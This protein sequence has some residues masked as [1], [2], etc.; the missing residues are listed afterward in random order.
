MTNIIFITSRL[1]ENHGGLTSSLLNKARILYNEKN[2]NSII[3]TFH[4]VTNFND[5]TSS[6]LERYKLEGKAEIYNI[7]EYFREKNLTFEHNKYNIDTSIYTSIKINDNKY[8][9]Y[10]YGLKRLEIFYSKNKIKEVK[11]FNKNNIC[12]SKDVIDIDGYLYWQSYYLNNHLSR[13]VFFRKDKTPFLTREFDAVNK[14]DK[15]ISLVL[16]EDKPIRF[17]SFNEFKE[18]FINYYIKAPI[19]YL[20]GEA[21][22]LDSVILNIKNDYA[23]KIFMTHS[24]HIRPDTDIIRAG[25]RKVLENLNEINALVLLTEK[26]KEDINKRFGHRDNYYVIPHSIAIPEVNQEKVDNK[27]VIISRLH[28]EKRLDHSIKAFEKVTKKIPNANLYIYGDGEEK[29]NLQNLI[30][31]LKLKNHVKLMGYSKEVNKILQSADCSLLTSQYEG[32]ALVV[33]ESIA[34]GTPVIAYDIKYGPSDMIDNDRNG[35]LVENNNINELSNCII[36]YLNKSQK[37][38]AKYSNAAITKARNFSNQRFA[39]S[40]VDLFDNLKIKSDE[41]NPTVKLIGLKHNQF[42]KSKYKIHLEVKLNSQNDVEPIFNGNVSHRSTTD[43]QETKIVNSVN[44]KILTSEKDL[45]NIELDFDAKLYKKREI[46]DINLS[47]KNKSKFFNLRIGDKTKKINLD[48]FSHRKCKP[49]YTDKYS[50]L[51]FEL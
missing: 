17:N 23:R 12:T 28:P 50:N 19:T 44:T 20:V 2:L 29:S 31:K 47:I 11:H 16:F 26:Q 10:K 51:S 4:A 1:D 45:F 41:M 25:N 27:V 9:F 39:N 13:Q 15:I 32:F 35:Y 37:D 34:N 7:N 49:F 5:V 14:S 8:E 3:L 24:I 36:K 48:K 43:N 40:W 38:K 18:Y 6:I 42:N 30:N 46:Y 22:G 21:R 33:Q